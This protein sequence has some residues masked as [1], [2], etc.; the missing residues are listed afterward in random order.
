VL[1]A[2]VG[3]GLVLAGTVAA[4][5]L[6]A[7][8]ERP[9]GS[10][11]FDQSITSW[12]VAH[13]TGALTVIARVFS[14]I[15]SQKVLI[16][17]VAVVAVALAGMRRRGSLAALVVCWGGAIVL[18]S[19]AKYFVSRHRPPMDIWLTRVAGT[20][21]PSGHAMQSLSTFL[22]L[23]FVGAAAMARLR[24]PARALAVGLGLGVG[25]S[26]VYLGV[27]W[28]TDVFAGWLMALVWVAMIL[29]LTR[30]AVI[31]IG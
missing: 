30:P 27:H 21:F 12:M 2:V 7:L 3:F 25:W 13:R 28:T 10:T 6:L 31:P 20:S 26:R 15:G 17:L 29:R 22:A 14:A 1:F 18:Y 16:P 23:A 9:D 11:G 4:G 8:A 5:H 19:V 24:W